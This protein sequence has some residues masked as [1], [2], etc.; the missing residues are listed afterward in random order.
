MAKFELSHET[1]KNLLVL[2]QVRNKDG[3]LISHEESNPD[4]RTGNS[5]VSWA[6]ACFI[7]DT[8]PI[9]TARITKMLNFKVV[10]FHYRYYL[11]Y[12]NLLIHESL[13]YTSSGIFW[14]IIPEYHC[15]SSKRKG[16]KFFF[17]LKDYVR[18]D[19][20]GRTLE[21]T[22]MIQVKQGYEPLNFTGHF[23]AWDRDVWSV[24]LNLHITSFGKTWLLRFTGLMAE[25]RR[26]HMNVSS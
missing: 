17:P 5:I 12:S 2:P 13:L 11:N 3:N 7:Y 18:S 20:S 4:P 24:S 15:K 10:N 9:P 16:K 1:R 22:M 8:R 26:K 14:E 23:Q 25:S 6:I 21:D 19:P